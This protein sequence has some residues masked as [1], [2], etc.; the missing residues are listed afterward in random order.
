MQARHIAVHRMVVEVDTQYALGTVVAGVVEV[1][2]QYA[3]GT[4]VAGVV[5]LVVPT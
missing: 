4:V 1:D 5:V 3:L 2:T